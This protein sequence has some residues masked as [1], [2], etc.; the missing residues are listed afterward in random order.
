MRH[1]AVNFSTKLPNTVLSCGSF[2]YYTCKQMKIS[3]G[4]LVI[5]FNTKLAKLRHL[6]VDLNTAKN[7]PFCG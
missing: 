3:M 1:L 4:Y 2:D 5:N 7:A 6:V